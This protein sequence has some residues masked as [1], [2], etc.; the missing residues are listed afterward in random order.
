MLSPQTG[1]HPTPMRHAQQTESPAPESPAP[2]R[3]DIRLNANGRGFGLRQDLGRIR[4]CKSARGK[5]AAWT[6]LCDSSSAP[7]KRYCIAVVTSQTGQVFKRLT[8][9]LQKLL[10]IRKNKRFGN[11]SSESFIRT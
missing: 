10:G 9:A 2:L 6:G 7:F 8:E 1:C 3:R 11:T 4:D 5:L